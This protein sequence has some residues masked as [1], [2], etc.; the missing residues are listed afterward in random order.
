[1]VLGEILRRNRAM[2]KKTYVVFGDAVKCFDKLWLKDCL[3]EMFSAGCN[4]QDIQLM[5]Q[6]NSEAEITIDTPLGKTEK[7]KVSNIVKQGTVLGPDLCCIETDQV[8]KIGEHQERYVGEQVVGILV[9]VD[10]VMSAGTAEEVRKA[11]RNFAEMERRKKFTYGLKKTK[12]MVIKTGK[13]Y[14]EEIN[15][16]V[17]EGTVGRTDEYKWLGLLLSEEGNLLKHIESKKE[18]NVGASHSYEEPGKLHECWPA[19]HT[20]Q[21]GALGGMHNTVNV[22]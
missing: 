5:Y 3:L 21:I 20:D 1:M 15:E 4:L 9:F 14:E 7:Q 10:D 11:I 8:N 6:L 12:Y 19:I 13:G 22:I 18:E 2:G 16:R 17:K